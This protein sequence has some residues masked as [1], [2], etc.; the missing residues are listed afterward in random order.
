MITGMM[1]PFFYFTALI[2]VHE[3]GHLFFA[4][5]FHWKI[6]KVTILPWGGLTV[7]QE[8]M[9]RPW[10]EEFCI[11]FGGPFFQTVFVSFLN[12]PDYVFTY[13]IL[14]LWFNFL[15]IIPLDG[16]KLWNLLFQKFFPFKFAYACTLLLSCLFLI[17]SFLIVFTLPHPLFLILALLCLVRDTVL[18]VQKKELLWQKF[19]LERYLYVFSFSKE[20]KIMGYHT[21]QMKRDYRHLFYIDYKW[22]PERVALVKTFDFPENIC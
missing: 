7:F 4:L 8:K 21:E 18:A 11:L 20:R 3:L 22:V 12:G 14:L 15:P 6:D 16:S 19:L 2:L 5:L 17:V 1:K 13:H 10:I 9:N